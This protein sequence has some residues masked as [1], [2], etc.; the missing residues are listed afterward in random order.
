M[1]SKAST[2]SLPV[3]PRF[4]KIIITVCIASEIPFPGHDYVCIPTPLR[5]F[6]NRTVH[7]DISKVF[8]NTPDFKQTKFAEIGIVRRVTHDGDEENR[9][10]L[11]WLAVSS[12]MR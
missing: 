3:A 2:D 1:T 11:A 5:L 7:A 10:G 6:P 8:L 4:Y 12:E 9:S